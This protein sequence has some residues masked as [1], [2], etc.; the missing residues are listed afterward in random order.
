MIISSREWILKEF[1]N[2]KMKIEK[3]NDNK[4]IYTDRIQMINDLTN[5]VYGNKLK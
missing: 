1:E 2:L 3:K 5:Y 4:H